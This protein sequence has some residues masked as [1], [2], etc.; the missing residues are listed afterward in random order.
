MHHV[1]MENSVKFLIILLRKHHS[2]RKYRGESDNKDGT[3][4]C[5]TENCKHV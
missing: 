2:N 1:V 5:I 3:K 4:K